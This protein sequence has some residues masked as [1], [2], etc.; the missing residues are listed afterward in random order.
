MAQ[1]RETIGRLIRMGR[2]VA[3]LSEK[4][5]AS[6]PDGG[7]V[8]VIANPVRL[9]ETPADYRLPPPLLGQHTDELLKQA[10]GLDEAK[11]AELRGKGVI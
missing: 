3:S 5:H 1:D 10:L 7:T 6:L 11:L 8:K 9:S 4:P 2:R